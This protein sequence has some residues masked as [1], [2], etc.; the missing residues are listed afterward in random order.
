MVW[1][2]ILSFNP[3]VLLSDVSVQ[4]L[5]LKK[6]IKKKITESV[7]TSCFWF[8]ST[9]SWDQVRESGSFSRY[10]ILAPF[11][12]P[13]E[14]SNLKGLVFYTEQFKAL[15]IWNVSDEQKPNTAAPLP[16]RYCAD[17][18]SSWHELE[19]VFCSV[20]GSVRLCALIAAPRAQIFPQFSFFFLFISALFNNADTVNLTPNFQ[21]C[22]WLKYPFNPL[23]DLVISPVM[24]A[25]DQPAALHDRQPNDATYL[26]VH[27]SLLHLHLSPKLACPSWTVNVCAYEKKRMFSPVL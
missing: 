26:N 24:A 7:F 20:R 18:S 21:S 13:S 23:S 11:K 14:A 1:T 12:A 3:V 15:E 22:W 17:L 16:T 8:A 9:S 25:V 4:D 2:V 10:E 5:E 27:L 6:K 19:S